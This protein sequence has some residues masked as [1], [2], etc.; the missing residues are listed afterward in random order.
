MSNIIGRRRRAF[1]QEEKNALRLG[2][3]K[4]GVGKWSLIKSEYNEIFR[5]RSAVQIKD[6][7]RTLA[8]NS[9]L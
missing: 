9:A 6:L 1:T 2:I 8:K 7:Y 4:F 3:K 5:Y